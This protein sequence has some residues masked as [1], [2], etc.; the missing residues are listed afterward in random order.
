MNTA[1]FAADGRCLC[2]GHGVLDLADV[3]AACAA[4]PVPHGTTPD[5]IWLDGDDVRTRAPMALEIGAGTI[6]GIPA[7]ALLE[8]AGVP[9][10]PWRIDDGVAEMATAWPQRLAVR[11][12]HPAWLPAELEVQT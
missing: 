8:I 1:F 10:G 3:P 9:G 5:A 6:S 2:I 11:I 12:T 7:G 4:H